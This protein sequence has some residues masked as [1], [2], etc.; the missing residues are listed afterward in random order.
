MEINKRFLPIILGIGILVLLFSLG[1]AFISGRSSPAIT[2]LTLAGAAGFFLSL[3]FIF[4]HM[5]KRFSAARI[6]QWGT[7]FFIVIFLLIAL[8]GINYSAAKVNYRLDLT[9]GKQHTLS[10]STLRFIKNL[11]QKIQLTVFYVGIPPKYLEDLLN[12]YKRLN[13]AFVETEIVDPLA[14]IGY[15]AQFGNVISGEER[16]VIVRSGKEKREVDFK[17][18]PL[19]EEGL[20]NAII[21]TTRKPKTIYF[22]AG[23][24]E[25]GLK[26]TKETGYKNFSGLLEEN[27]SRVFE[28][29]LGTKKQIPEDCE[30]LVIAGAKN[31]LSEKEEKIIQDY[32]EGGGEALFLIESMPISAPETPLTESEKLKNPTFNGI[33]KRWGVSLGDDIVVDME[34]HAGADVGCP[35]TKNYP[36]HKEIVNGLD[37]TFFIRPRSVSILA[38]H[39]ESVK[40]APLIW[41]ASA[42]SSWAETS[43]NLVVKYDEKED[44]KGPIN[45]AAVVWEPKSE[46]KN[47]DTKIIV[48]ADADFLNNNFMKE[49]SNA[50]LGLNAI[51]W[52]SESANFLPIKRK[53]IEVDT[54]SLTSRELRIIALVLIAIPLMIVLAG[55]GVWWKRFSAI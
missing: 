10:D 51:G 4:A 42:N 25:S 33:L 18:E 9:R 24:G 41:T 5:A 26:D 1:T 31:P 23:H 38:D 19:S 46:N 43:K 48:I 55:M 30:V 15:A 37:Y 36:P 49:Y 44:K 40:T 7:V 16:K 22:L 50:Q 35:A 34:N 13:P 39:P 27:N 28:L 2:A 20:T 8:V 17:E 6:R 52:L 54:V 45:L 11:E 29:L 12:E 53:D 21:K 14:Q 32:L 3:I 47:S